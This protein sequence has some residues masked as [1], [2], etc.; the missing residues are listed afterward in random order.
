LKVPA[1]ERPQLHAEQEKASW[2]FAN[3]Q[4]ADQQNANF[5]NV[6]IKMSQILINLP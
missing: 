6:S 4:N 3:F 5:Q 1:A 2:F